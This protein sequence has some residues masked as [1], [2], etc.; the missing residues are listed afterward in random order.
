MVLHASMSFLPG[1]TIWV[2]GDVSR[3]PVPAVLFF[4]IHAMRMATFFFIAGFFGR[5]LLERLGTGGF[6]R[7]RVQRIALPLLLWWAPTLAAVIAVATAATPGAVAAAPALGLDSFP[8]THLWF[9]YVLL[10]AYAGA[11]LGRGALRLVDRHARIPRA[12]DGV[13]ARVASPPGVGLL[14]LP[15]AW[16][17]YAHPYWLPW[18]GIPTPDMSLR[19]NRAAVVTYGAAFLLGWAMQRRRDEHLARLRARWAWHSALALGATA[20]C[21]ALIGPVPVLFPAPFDVAKARYAA[22]Y[23]VAIWSWV[24][25]LLG[26]GL[27]FLAR[28]SRSV[29]YLADASYWIYLTHLPLVMALQLAVSRWAIAW[30]I[31]LPLVV[32]ITMALLLVTYRWGVRTTAIGVLL[33]GRRI[34][35]ASQ[36]PLPPDIP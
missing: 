1:P 29:R 15:V 14:A 2:V 13:L 10:W 30:W 21:L 25:A 16:A 28:P 26:L 4:V 18:F 8:L 31:K 27:R 33:H 32:T 11:L 22:L 3:S 20:G 36:S 34:P 35:R 6:V 19:P 7:D 24:F 12:I 23:A 9:L 5:G 17:L